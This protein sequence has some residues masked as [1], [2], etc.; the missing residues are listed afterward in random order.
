[1]PSPSRRVRTLFAEVETLAA[2]LIE[3]SVEE[4]RLRE[5]LKQVWRS[6]TVAMATMAA[7][8]YEASQI[9]VAEQ[10]KARKR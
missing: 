4:Q 7:K 2:Q 9:E 8:A 6:R 10:Q 5:L 1:M 3:L